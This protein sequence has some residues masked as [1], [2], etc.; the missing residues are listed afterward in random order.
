MFRTEEER[1]R[2]AIGLF[3]IGVILIGFWWFE[4]NM[5]H[6]CQMAGGKVETFAGGVERCNPKT[7][8]WGKGCTDTA[9]C[10]G[11]CLVEHATDTTGTCSEYR[12][13][14]GCRNGMYQGRVAQLCWAN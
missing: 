5:G 12:Y 2:T 7:T 13:F 9:E 1:R 8:D 11:A 3:L 4:Q 10:Q 6:I 14:S